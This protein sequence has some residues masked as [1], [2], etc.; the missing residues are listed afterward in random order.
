[1][2]NS[3]GL[4]RHNLKL[5]ASEHTSVRLGTNGVSINFVSLTGVKIAVNN[6]GWRLPGDLGSIEKNAN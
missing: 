1:M 2:W 5:Q 3:E 4:K 6:V